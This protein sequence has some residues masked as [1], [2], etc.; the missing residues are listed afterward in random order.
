MY[1]A[2]YLE[3]IIIIEMPN[4]LTEQISRYIRV[5]LERID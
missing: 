2:R 3:R 4:C 1:I 5:T